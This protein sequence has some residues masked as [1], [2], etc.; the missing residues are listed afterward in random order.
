MNRTVWQEVPVEAERIIYVNRTQ[1][2]EVPVEIEKIVYMNQ[3]IEVEKVTKA[4]ANES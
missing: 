2:F 1:V 3:T 4:P